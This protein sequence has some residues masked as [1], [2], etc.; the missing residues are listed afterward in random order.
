M[1]FPEELRRDREWLA[2]RKIAE[3]IAD[4]PIE[5]LIA[6]GAVRMLP[7]A[8]DELVRLR[9]LREALPAILEMLTER[10][11]QVLRLRF[12]LNGL[13]EHSLTETARELKVGLE[14]V[15]QIESKALRKLRHPT[16]AGKLREFAK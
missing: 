4:L 3:T 6:S 14:R 16:L 1:I 5:Q 7:P 8:P 15:R 13:D 12:G 9:E 11:Q 2:Q 10:E